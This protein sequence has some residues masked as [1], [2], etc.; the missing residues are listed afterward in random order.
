MVLGMHRSETS[1]LAGSLQQYGVYL[2]RVFEWNPYNPK[3]NRENADIMQLNNSILAFNQGS[4][5][6]PPVSLTWQEQHK[7]ARDHIIR[8]FLESEYPICGF[9]DPRTLFTLE[10]W[11][12]GLTNT[13]VKFVGSFRH[14]KATVRSLESRD[15]MPPQRGFL[16]WER[17][18]IQLLKYQETHGFPLISFDVDADEYQSS[19]NRVLYQLGIPSSAEVIE[20]FFDNDF[21][22][23]SR[24]D[25]L[26]PAGTTLEIY[27]RL[28]QIYK[29][30]GL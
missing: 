21:R 14:P 26:S 12:D 2:G 8:G 30:Q 22:H 29:D 25:S 10:F 13:N 18:N 24:E 17:Y 23:E 3:G 6:N 4:W 28:L 7:E 19:L 27:D 16:L 1:A 15:K 9:K 11:L 5:D 20:P